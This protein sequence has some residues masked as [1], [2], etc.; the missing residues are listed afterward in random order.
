VLRR[1]EKT[2]VPL[3]EVVD[4]DL[5]AREVHLDTV[6]QSSVVPYDSSIVAGGAAQSIFRP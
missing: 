1:Q 5:R 6:G 2:R 3:G 4:I